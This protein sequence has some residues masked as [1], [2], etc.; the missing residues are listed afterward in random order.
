MLSVTSKLLVA[1]IDLGT[2]GSG[3]GYSFRSDYEKDP[4]KVYTR[5]WN[6][7]CLRS[8]K[9][10]TCVLCDP[11]GH[12]DSFGH[13]AE[14]KYCRLSEDKEHYNWYFL[15]NF[16]N[17]LSEKQVNMEF[18]L[19][20]EKGLKMPAIQVFSMAIR[21]LKDDLLDNFKS[22]L[23]LRENEFHWVLPVPAT[24]S[25]S[26]KEFFREAAI[27]AGI[28]G[29]NLTIALEHDAAAVYCEALTSMGLSCGGLLDD[30]YMVI[31]L[32]GTIL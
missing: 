1:A 23:D 19:T 10:P 30:K 24:W 29:E 7:G 11:A 5:T 16:I 12:F 14:D 27:K 3:Y 2:D 22:H 15:R 28:N 25:V 26:A 13:E 17:M 4:M 18:E 31:D 8:S 32:G 9:Q 6:S 20:D 21:Y